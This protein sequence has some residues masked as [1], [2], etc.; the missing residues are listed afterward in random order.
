MRVG[1][2]IPKLRK[3]SRYIVDTMHLFCPM[4]NI[5]YSFSLV[6][7]IMYRNSSTNIAKDSYRTLRC[8][9]KNFDIFEEAGELSQTAGYCV[10]QRIKLCHI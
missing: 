2:N 4:L 3:M 7:G 8:L 10:V 6:V 9:T 1:S 5:Q